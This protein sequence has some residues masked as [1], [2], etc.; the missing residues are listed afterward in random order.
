MCAADTKCLVDNGNRWRDC[1]SERY[2]IPAEQVGQS[3]HRVLAT[4]RAEIDG[5]LAINNGSREWPTTRIAT[6]CTLGLRQKI[7]D[8][9]Y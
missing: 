4:W 2:D 7:I 6:L 3:S 5:G 1:L 8:S 9:L